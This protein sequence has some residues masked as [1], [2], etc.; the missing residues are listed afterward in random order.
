MKR[1]RRF[2]NVHSDVGETLGGFAHAIIDFSLRTRYTESLGNDPYAKSRGAFCD[3][4]CV[5]LAGGSR[6]ARIKT[7]GPRKNFEHQRIVSDCTGDR[8]GMVNG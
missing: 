7:I 1:Q 2:T 4:L 6:L 8:S 3:R 5:Q